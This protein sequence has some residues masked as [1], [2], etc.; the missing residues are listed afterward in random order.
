MRFAA[1]LACLAI[2]ACQPAPRHRMVMETQGATRSPGAASG[3]VGAAWAGDAG[4]PGADGGADPSWCDALATC[5]ATLDALD[6]TRTSCDDTLAHGD[7][8]D[9]ATRLTFDLAWCE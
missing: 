4:S 5:C 2:T 1:L 3:A 9:C 7:E 8:G 6:P